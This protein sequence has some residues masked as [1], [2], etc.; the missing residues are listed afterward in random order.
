MK[1]SE[2]Q[3]YHGSN[4]HFEEFSADHIGTGKGYQTFGWGI[5]LS[6]EK[7]IAKRYRKRGVGKIYVVDMPDPN[8]MLD[9][10]K[11][12]SQQ[13][14]HVQ[15]CL[16][17]FHYI[18]MRDEMIEK[19]MVTGYDKTDYRTDKGEDIYGLISSYFITINP[20]ESFEEYRKKTSIF[21]SKIGIP[22]IKFFDVESFR[23][24]LE[25]YVIFD[26]HRITIKKTLK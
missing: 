19:E 15:Q 12:F 25:N 22:G 1:L 9:W 13:S 5:Y 20:H 11:T 23:N 14:S 26:P 8:D 3:A 10:N 17:K 2:T 18:E 4:H 7:N 16:L 6:K 21:L 24:T